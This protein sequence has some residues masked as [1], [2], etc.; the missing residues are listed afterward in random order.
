MRPVF[1]LCRAWAVET[2][3]KDSVTNQSSTN[4]TG[5]FEPHILSKSVVSNLLWITWACVWG[6]GKNN[7][8]LSEAPYSGSLWPG[9][10]GPVLLWLFAFVFK[11][12]SHW[13]AFYFFTQER[14]PLA[15]MSPESRNLH[16]FCRVQEWFSNVNFRPLPWSCRF[17]EMHIE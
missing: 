16:Q 17:I 5:E 9:R 4:L 12:S 3:R 13:T 1:S 11:L 6:I 7:D 8:L 10:C 14:F 2:M 15:V